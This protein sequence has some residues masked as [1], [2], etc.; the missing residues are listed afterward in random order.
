[1]RRRDCKICYR[2]LDVGEWQE[3]V[4]KPCRKVLNRQKFLETLGKGMTKFNMKSVTKDS[5]NQEASQISKIGQ[6]YG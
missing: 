1:M 6:Y 2:E 4:C 5:D 3:G